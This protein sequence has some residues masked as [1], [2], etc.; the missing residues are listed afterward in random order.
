MEK[1]KKIWK[2]FHFLSVVLSVCMMVL[3]VLMIIFPNT[4]IIVICSVLGAICAIFGIGETVRYFKMKKIGMFFGFDLALGICSIIIGA[5]LLIHPKGAAA[6]FPF[7]V[8][9]YIL[10]D[11]AFDIQTAVEMKKCG[12]GNWALALI[13]S[14]TSAV[15]AIF[16]II[17]PFGGAEAFAVFIGISLV[18]HGI[19]NLYSLFCLTKVIKSDRS[20]IIVDFD[21]D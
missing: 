21:K 19:E 8:G 6:V 11:S 7:I 18:F 10:I 4:S 20:D 3:G 12:I 15:F 1:I 16:L 5:V 17:N 13:L 14:I 9:I 2:R